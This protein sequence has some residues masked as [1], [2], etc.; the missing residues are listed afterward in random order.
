MRTRTRPQAGFA[1]AAPGT[2]SVAGM[3][4]VAGI[5][6]VAG[7]ARIAPG[8]AL[9][10]RPRFAPVDAPAEGERPPAQLPA[11]ARDRLQ[12]SSP[13]VRAVLL[14]AADGPYAFGQQ[15]E[16]ALLPQQL[17]QLVRPPSEVFK[18]KYL[19]GVA[20]VFDLAAPR[21]HPA[22]APATTG[23]RA[24]PTPATRA[25]G[26][27][28]AGLHVAHASAVR[29]PPRGNALTRVAQSAE[30]VPAR[31]TVA[32]KLRRRLLA[33][34][35][36]PLTQP[37]NPRSPG[38]AT[39]MTIEQAVER[40]EHHVRFP[41]TRQTQARLAQ[42][43]VLAEVRALAQV[44][45]DQPQQGPQPLQRLARV[46]NRGLRGDGPPGALQEIDRL[47]ELAKSDAPEAIALALPREELKAPVLLAAPPRRATFAL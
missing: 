9:D 18:A 47:R 28:E 22:Q 19:G 7:M 31:R 15:R 24:L 20:Q 46:V 6:S 10:E 11:P 42:H 3:A 16:V 44:P 43:S 33:L 5:T 8:D 39:G 2:A 34:G 21:V 25:I 26:V 13:G 17:R 30:D 35:Q 45:P 4:S 29:Q 32:E 41:R 38:E 1:P 27:A 36:E 23:G 37:P 40:G 12:Q 14:A